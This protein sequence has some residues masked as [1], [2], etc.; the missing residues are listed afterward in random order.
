MGITLTTPE[1][2]VRNKDAPA[3]PLLPVEDGGPITA[4]GVTLAV[5]ARASTPTD[6]RLCRQASGKVKDAD[7]K[8]VKDADGKDRT[9]TV[10]RQTGRVED[11]ARAVF[12]GLYSFEK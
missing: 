8:V 3:P 9:E 12:G 4:S 7:G 5:C 6:L 1:Q 11:H 10:W 2:T